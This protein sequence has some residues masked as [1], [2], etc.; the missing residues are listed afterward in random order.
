MFYYAQLNDIG[1]CVGI[2]SSSNSINQLNM[3]DL[4]F[5]DYDKLY[6]KYTD[7]VWSEEK[8]PD[9]FVKTP[10]DYLDDKIDE[11]NAACR[12]AIES[13]FY[14]NGKLFKS[15]VD[16]DQNNIALAG[17]Q[18]LTTPTVIIPWE[19][20]DNEIVMLSFEDFQS[21]SQAFANHKME[22]QTKVSTLKAQAK[23][24]D[25][26]SETFMEQLSLIVW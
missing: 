25:L 6:K 9:G 16:P 24:L 19:T 8:Y 12:V 22:N 10:Q 15:A 4:E 17:L 3:I 1:I 13:G 11:L 21:F 26:E 14:W 18:F 20:A 7:G 2:S 23:A 5:E